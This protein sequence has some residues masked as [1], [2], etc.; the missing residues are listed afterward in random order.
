M[1]AKCLLVKIFLHK[2]TI[3]YN[4]LAKRLKTHNSGKASRYTRG[5][6]PVTVLKTFEVAD[7]SQALKLEYKLKQLSREEKLKL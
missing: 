3:I 2:R 4:D 1:V 6:L 7:K 5:R